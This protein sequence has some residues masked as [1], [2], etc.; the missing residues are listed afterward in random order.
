MVPVLHNGSRF[1]TSTAFGSMNRWAY[2]NKGS[3]IKFG[4][5][6]RNYQVSFKNSE[7]FIF[8]LVY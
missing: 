7:K 4:G 8:F 2:T 6:E 5:E 3:K 1:G